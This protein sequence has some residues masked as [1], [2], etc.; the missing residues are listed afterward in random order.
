MKKKKWSVK[1][2]IGDGKNWEAYQAA[3]EGKVRENQVREVEKMLGCGKEAGGYATYVC[4]GCGEEK[5][6]EFSGK[7]R[8]CS[9]CGKQH[10]D[11][12]AKQLTGRLFNV[13]HRHITFTIPQEMWEILER[14]P[15][16]RKVLFEGVNATLRGVMKVQM[17]A[18]AVLH[19]YGKDLKVNYHI[20][21]PVTEGGIDE[22]GKWQARK[23]I[24]YKGLRKVWQYEVLTRLKAQM[25]A[26]E[27][28]DQ[29]IDKL[30]KCYKEGFYVHAAPKVTD[31]NGVS[32]Y[33]GRYIRHPAIADSRIVAYDGKTVAFY[34]K[35]RSA[36]RRSRELKTLP[37]LAFI[38][39]IVRHIPPKQFKMVRYFGIYAPRKRSAVQ[40]IAQEIGKMVGRAVRRLN[41]RSRI[42]RD[43]GH[44]PLRCSKCGDEMLLSIS[45]SNVKQFIMPAQY[46]KEN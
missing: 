4:I 12:W 18:V 32:R 6:V 42:Q 3:Y 44:D 7:S 33:I 36:G 26:G 23:Y 37:V 38:H 28:T 5:R 19:P 9:G 46:N 1:E 35:K 11:E 45:R 21:A 43:F 8:V 13:V 17:G 15:A 41:W 22:K 39:G 10:A 29:W 25:P 16:Y 2:I 24:N 34:Y 30:F 31:G 27:K 14:E 40:Q 20:H